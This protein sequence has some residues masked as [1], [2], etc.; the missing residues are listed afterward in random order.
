MIGLQSSTVNYVLR[1]GK[2]QRYHAKTPIKPQSVGEHT[3]GVAWLC[4]LLT[5]YNPGQSLLMAALAH[6]TAEVTTGDVPA[7]VKRL[8]NGAL[9]DMERD[10]LE[11][12]DIDPRKFALTAEEAHL[13]SIADKLEGYAY[14]V[15]EMRM[16]NMTMN[17]TAERYHDYLRAMELP[18][19]ARQ[20]LQQI[21]ESINE[22]E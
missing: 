20:L 15:H 18:L 4:V 21:T 19:R 13:L 1:S 17:R 6:D 10:A 22:R 7:P 16:G 9:D 11:R 5:D 2:V 3:Y 14:C 12:H 8:L